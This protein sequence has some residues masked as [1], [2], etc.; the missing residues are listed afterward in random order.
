LQIALEA[1]YLFTD[2]DNKLGKKNY[3]DFIDTRHNQSVLS[4][5]SKKYGIPAFR[6]PSQWGWGQGIIH[7]LSQ[8]CRAKQT[9]EVYPTVFLLHRSRKV[10]VLSVSAVIFQNLFPRSFKTVNRIRKTMRMSK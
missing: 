5:L 9:Q 1:P 4:V 7:I 2:D 8:K 10:T 3:E 6:N